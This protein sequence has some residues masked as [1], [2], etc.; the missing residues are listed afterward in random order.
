MN[1]LE[2]R[3]HNQRLGLG[4]FAVYLL[5]YVGFMLLCAFAPAVMELRPMGG[6]NLALLYGFGLIIAAV[7]LA[8]IYGGL[9]R[10]APP[11]ADAADA[12]KADGKEAEQEA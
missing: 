11:P 2:N 12:G 6:L 1:E 3:R 5:L 10:V 7:V 8:M 9:C 4:L